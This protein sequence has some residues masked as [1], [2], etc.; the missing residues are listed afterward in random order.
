MP[1]LIGCGLLGPRLA[2]ILK[3]PAPQLVGPMLVSAAAHLAAVTTATPPL[4][5]VFAAQTVIGGAIGCRFGGVAP[6]TL[7]TVATSAL[8]ACPALHSP[9]LCPISALH[10]YHA[11]RQ[12][13]NPRALFES[14]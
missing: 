4:A 6:A 8:C 11:P 1:V 2:H 3:L 9:R 5:L 10:I 7:L 13:R 12:T 14:T